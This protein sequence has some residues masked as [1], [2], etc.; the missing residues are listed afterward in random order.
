[1]C[2][3]SHL[4]VLL[5]LS[6]V[7]VAACAQEPAPPGSEARRRNATT[8]ATGT[9][10]PPPRL[11]FAVKGDWGAGTSEQAEITSRMCE[12]RAATP[13]DQVV[14]T[15]DNFYSPDGVATQ[16]NYY[17]P[18]ACLLAHPGHRWRAA[19]GNHDAGRPSTD[20]VLGAG[21][22]TYTWFDNPVQF[23]VLDSNRAADASQ[24]AWLAGELARS[25]AAVKI[26]VFHHPPFTVGLHE[27]SLEVRRRWVPLFEQHGV[28]LVLNGH[29]H[30]YEHSVIN[31]V[32]YV[33]SGGG[34]AS[35]YPCV[36][37]EP[38]LIVCLSAHHFLVV[39]AE[40]TSISVKAIGAFGAQIDG[41]NL[42]ESNG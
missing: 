35:L 17:R 13:F 31:G 41:F 12:A 2:R 33:V 9:A 34:G 36:D 15:G 6:M 23:F 26:A 24:T 18:E 22:R 20:Q 11:V 39:E 10:T 25:T 1:M 38:W 29:N 28:D 7:S 27:D 3:R 37:D 30:G 32:H 8:D 19:W 16:A 5:A 14:T 21:E 4:S 40:G 42:V